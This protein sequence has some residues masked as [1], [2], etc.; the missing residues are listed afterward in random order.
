MSDRSKD[1]EKRLFHR[2]RDLLDSEHV[3]SVGMCP[4]YHTSQMIKLLR[5]LFVILQQKNYSFSSETDC[6]SERD[7]SKRLI[8]FLFLFLFRQCF[9]LFRHRCWFFATKCLF[10]PDPISFSPHF[11]A[12]LMFTSQIISPKRENIFRRNIHRDVR[13]S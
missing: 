10:S 13:V 3:C 7:V 2:R 12:I 11:P 9:S 1:S 8:C 4:I 6:T 5:V